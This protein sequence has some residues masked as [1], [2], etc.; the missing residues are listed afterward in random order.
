MNTYMVDGR[1]ALAIA[2]KMVFLIAAT[3][4]I[5]AA[6]RAF[7]EPLQVPLGHEVVNTVR[8]GR[9]REGVPFQNSLIHLE[10]LEA[11]IKS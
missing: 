6:K 9:I 1:R 3:P 4:L 10:I 11:S 5:G 8:E 7:V 2:Y